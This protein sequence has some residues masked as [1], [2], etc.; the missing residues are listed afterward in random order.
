MAKGVRMTID[1]TIEKSTV[2]LTVSGR[3]DA[4]NASLLERKIKQWGDEITEIILDFA[5][6]TYISSVGLRVLLHAKKAFSK[7]NRKL[8]I[9]NMGETVREVFEITG[10]LKLMVDEEQFVLIR[11]EHDSGGVVLSFNGQMQTGDNIE[12]VEKE[13]SDIR[14]V[15]L[16]WETPVTVIFDMTNLVDISPHA[17]KLLEQA[18]HRTAWE[19]RIIKVRGASPEIENLLKYEGLRDLFV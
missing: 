1:Q 13:L 5:D 12:A 4:V 7:I 3:L 10:F 8:V 2:V 15:G 19:K 11:K 6:L 18:V 14:K 9:R 16:F 17:S